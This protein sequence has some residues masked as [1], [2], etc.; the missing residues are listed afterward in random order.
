MNGGQSR[1]RDGR[2]LIVNFRQIKQLQIGHVQ[3]AAR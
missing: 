2:Q 1:Y 3:V